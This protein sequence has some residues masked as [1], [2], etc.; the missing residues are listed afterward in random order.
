M[1]SSASQFATPTVN[2]QSAAS[3][4]DAA[5]SDTPLTITLLDIGQGDATLVTTPNGYTILIDGGPPGSGKHVTLPYMMDH[6]ITALNHVMASHYDSDHIGGISEILAGRDGI[7]DTSDDI[8]VTGYCWD[9]G[10]STIKSTP[11]FLAYA[12]AT[13]TCQRTA[14]PGDNIYFDDDVSI[15]VVAV[16][17][18]SR[19]G[20]LAETDSDDE[21]AA[22][23]VLLI[24]YGEFRYVTTGDLPGGG[25][26]PPYDTVDEESA[27]AP[28]IGHVDILHLGHHGSGTSSN[29]NFLKALSPDAV[30]ISVGD[31]NSYLHPNPGTLARLHDL[32]IPIYQTN[33][34]HNVGTQGSHIANGNIVIE[35]DG[36]SFEIRQNPKSH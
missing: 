25:G 3:N 22:S 19:F 10:N 26:N 18:R 24:R 14:L 30:V 21:N 20:I 16:N 8:R 36:N 31:N 11:S 7:A 13:T 35:T 12:Q 29:L 2:I 4:D 17:G 28:L 33:R 27:V 5:L 6:N 1:P 9:H 15:E 32:K 23:M 34:G